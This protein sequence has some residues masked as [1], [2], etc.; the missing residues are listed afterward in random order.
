[1]FCMFLLCI[2]HLRFLWFLSA[3]LFC[4]SNCLFAALLACMF[5]VLFVLLFM[6]CF[7]AIFLFPFAFL[8]PITRHKQYS[9]E[10]YRM[11]LLKWCH[12]SML[13]CLHTCT[14]IIPPHNLKMLHPPLR[15]PSQPQNLENTPPTTPGPLAANP[16]HEI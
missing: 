4:W 10:K 3:G 11:T 9:M 13:T 1:M 14:I 6:S 7:S 12:S 2:V 15:S 16:N 5:S 8:F